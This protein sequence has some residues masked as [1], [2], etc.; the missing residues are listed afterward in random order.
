MHVLDDVL[1]VDGQLG[2]PWLPQ[3][4]VQHRPVLRRV[5]V[6][7]GEHRVAALFQSRRAGQVHQQFQRLAGHAVLAVVDVQ[8][9]DGDG[10]LGAAGG[11]VGEQFAQVFFADLV[12]MP[13]Q[14]LPRGSGGD[15]GNLR[16]I[17]GHVAD[18]NAA[19]CPKV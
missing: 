10:Q 13:L 19:K 16:G 8:I 6:D 1:T 9:A 11:I 18:T 17:G 14:G 7:A 2:A 4:G 5:D 12:V 15:I 3:R